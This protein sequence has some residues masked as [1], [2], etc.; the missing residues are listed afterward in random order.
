MELIRL[1]RI[2]KVYDTGKIQVPVLNDVSLTIEQGELVALMGTSGSGKTTL[3]NILGCMDRPTGGRYWLD[4]E[5][6]STLDVN[7]QAR[8]RRRK[9]GFVFQSFNLL[10]RTSAVDNVLLP[11]DVTDEPITEQKKDQRA[12]ELLN[13]LGLGERLDH[14]PSQMSGG[15]QQ[16]VAIAR[17]LVNQPKL[18]LADEPTGNLD[19]RTTTEI[20]AMFQRLNAEG[21]TIV[22]VTH[23]PEVARHAK[24][25]IH[26][27]D[28]RV[29]DSVSRAKPELIEEVEENA[30]PAGKAP[31]AAGIGF[32][33]RSLPM[34]ATLRTALVALRRNIMRS[35]L[36][37]LGII[38]GIAAVIA[39]MEIG[40]GSRRAVQQTIASMGANN[41]LIL[42]GAATS[43]GV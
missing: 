43:A 8:L 18:L 6:V 25:V 13:R 39:M 10:P 20:L 32:G 31:A 28:G 19:S 23:D 4:G 21:L 2:E 11:L 9:I 17:S 37:A 27:K 16:R 7:E 34:P 42:P 3:M 14:E 1:E 26:I 5:E 35:A 12:L 40:G 15:Q 30:T 29:V 36:T 33:L 41:I 24:R 22:L 38:I